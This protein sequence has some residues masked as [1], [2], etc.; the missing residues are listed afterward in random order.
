MVIP[1][2]I[3]ISCGIYYFVYLI[4]KLKFKKIIISIFILLYL[5]FVAYYFD[6]YFF[7][8]AKRYPFAWQYEFDQLVPYVE[9]QKYKYQ[10]IYI[11]NK[12]DQPYILFL[13]FSQYPPTQIQSQ[14][15]LTP[16][17]K[18]GFSTV[19]SYD[20]YHFGSIDWNNI[21]SDSLVVAADETVPQS[22]QKIFYFTNSQPAF[23]IYQKP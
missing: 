23:K 13:F 19:A 17:D 14:I 7:H 2:T 10:N 12:Y 9:S 21:P 4:S 5:Y 22:P 8:Y 11:T 16:P 1:L 20:N 18:Y 6:S 3:F 15:K